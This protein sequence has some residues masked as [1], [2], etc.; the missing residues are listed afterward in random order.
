M[1]PLP[2]R[3]PR[4]RAVVLLLCALPALVS[5]AGCG[6]RVLLVDRGPQAHYQT[7]FPVQDTSGELERAFRSLQRVAYTAEYETFLFAAGAD[8]TEADL[9][10]PAVLERAAERRVE[11]DSKAG[12]AVIVARAETNMALVTNDHVVH[13]P[14]VR[15]YHVDEDALR[16]PRAQRRVASVSIRRGAWGVLGDHPELGTFT[17]MARDTVNDLA[18]LEVRLPEWVSPEAFPRI[19]VQPGDP[20]RLSWGSFVYVLGFPSGYAMVTRAIVSDPSRDRQ[21]SFLTDGLWNEGISGGAILAIRGDTG[22]LEWVGM[23]RAGAGTREVR[24]QPGGLDF[25]EEDEGVRYEGPVFAES[26]LRIQYGIT[27]SVPMTAVRAF[28]DE[29]RALLQQR[30]HNLRRY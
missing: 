17:V 11:L 3:P 5:L 20:A 1:A 2:P 4:A 29:H 27:L 21:G 23:A 28:L 7:G 19:G 10:D 8:V 13:F 6:T 24:L 12:T 22:A 25:I 18:A 26:A 15:I 9:A 30:G 14:A 16:L